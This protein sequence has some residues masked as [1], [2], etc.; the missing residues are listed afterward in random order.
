MESSG[1][2][3]RPAPAAP[4]PATATED[5]KTAPA[6]GLSESRPPPPLGP[7]ACQRA[8]GTWIPAEP[9][10]VNWSNARCEPVEWAA[11]IGQKPGVRRA[12]SPARTLN[13]RGPKFDKR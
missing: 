3:R 8:G 10:T 9:G 13:S 5:P 2:A 6:P 4:G 1:C 11:R 7:R 12:P